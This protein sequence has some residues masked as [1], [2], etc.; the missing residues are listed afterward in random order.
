MPISTPTACP[1]AS[2][3][4]SCG[5]SHDESTTATAIVASA[6]MGS[7][8]VCASSSA[9]EAGKPARSIRGM[10]VTGPDVPVSADRHPVA[11]SRG[12]VTTRRAW[13]AAGVAATDALA[14]LL[15]SSWACRLLASRRRR[16]PRLPVRGAR[17]RRFVRRS[18]VR[19]YTSCT[20]AAAEVSHMKEYSTTKTTG[21]ESSVSSQM[22]S[23][24]PTPASARQRG[25]ERR[26]ALRC[27]LACEGNKATRATAMTPAAV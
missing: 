10:P 15:A 9:N 5:R 19:L 4:A 21:P 23:E 25:S 11:K 13:N 12:A 7:C 18:L 6:A 3:T 1:R 14:S 24:A 8:T 20:R 17:W 26:A 27:A 22:P 2:G 16:P